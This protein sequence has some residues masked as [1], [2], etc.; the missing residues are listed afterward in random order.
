MLWRHWAPRCLVRP[1]DE[2]RP[3]RYRDPPTRRTLRSDSTLPTQGPWPCPRVRRTGPTHRTL[4]CPRPRRSDQGRGGTLSTLSSAYGTRRTRTRWLRSDRRG[5]HRR[6]RGAAPQDPREPFTCDR[7]GPRSSS[8]DR[9]RDIWQA[10]P[11]HTP[12]RCTRDRPAAQETDRA[13]EDRVGGKGTRCEYHD[14]RRRRARVREESE[15]TAPDRQ[16]GTRVHQGKGR[17]P[18]HRSTTPRYRMRVR[19]VDWRPE[20]RYIMR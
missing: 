12:Q 17:K 20:N 3:R 19:K 18:G 6:V 15:R 7:Q 16:D 8:A 2:G 11:R 4:R 1:T 13:D 14:R 9:R 10:P 5:I